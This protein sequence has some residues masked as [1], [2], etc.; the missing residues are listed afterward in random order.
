VKNAT[1]GESKLTH[2]A[3]GRVTSLTDF[4]GHTTTYDYTSG[5]PC[6][7]P[8]KIIN[9]DGTFRLYEY[10]SFGQTTLEVNELGHRTQWHYDDVGRLLSVTDAEGNTIRY[11]YE[12][13]LKTSETD[14]LGRTSRYAYND[15]NLQI[16]VTDAAGG[17]ARFEY[18]GNG[19]RTTVTDPVGNVTRFHYDGANRLT[20]EEDPYGHIRFY[21][22]DA[23][24]NRIEAIDRNGRRRT[25]EYDGLN[26]R[27]RELWWENG[28]VIRTFTYTFNALGV[29][30]GAG[31]PAGQLTF[32]Y[33]S[34][35]RLEQ[36]TQSGVPGLSDFTLNYAYDGMTNVVSVTD[37][38]GVQVTSDY[39]ARNRLSGRVWQGGGL[40]GASLRF[41]Y[42]PAGNRTRAERYADTAGTALV[43]QSA[44][45]YNPQG[46]MTDILHANGGGATLAEYHYQRDPAQQIVQ[47]VLNGQTADYGYDLTGQLTSAGFSAGQLNENY[48]YDANGN[49]IGGGYVVAPNNQIAADGTFTYGYDDEGSLVSRVSIA[50][51]ATTTY[52]FDHRNRLVSVVDT[53]SGGSVTQT[54]DFTY[55]ARDRRIAK[56]VNG[57]V[58]RFLLNQ[59]NIWADADGSGAITARYL[60]GNRID[61]MLARYRPG[62]A[63]VWYLGDH[64]STVRDLTDSTGVILNHIT[65]AAFGEVRSQLLAG[66][67]DRFL[68]TGRE[69]DPETG[70]IYMRA[71]YLSPA[72][73]RFISEDPLS[74]GQSDRNLYRYAA[75]S[76]LQYTDPSGM[77]AMIQFAIK[78]AALGTV[79]AALRAP[80]LNCGLGE[81]GDAVAKGLFVLAGGASGASLGAMIGGVY[82]YLGIGTNTLLPPTLISLPGYPIGPG[83]AAGIIGSLLA[84]LGYT[85]SGA[86]PLLDELVCDATAKALGRT[87][88]PLIV[89]DFGGS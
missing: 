5:C 28:A 80:G 38:W 83:R 41:D 26:R 15:A 42:D 23:A 27:T 53:D 12:G 4:N 29:M 71:R 79:V 60:L 56:S 77:I 1:G 10:N 39:D 25:F 20:R 9:P 55:D 7:K 74:F 18:D 69:L 70:L 37:N 21:T 22:Y 3:E 11:A 86:G 58:T 30:T 81:D 66:A 47:R 2:D 48:S 50:T 57:T 73:G 88:Q 19:N 40:L 44:Y 43:G 59:E 35:N 89:T 32:R 51:G 61:E 8:G 46:V 64:L 63:V 87:R 82:L 34:L 72:L 67:S 84:Y 75:N 24:G 36:A 49:R 85:H 65:Y 14:P 52:R 13:A 31:D 16:A 54:V 68:F 76:P 6:G 17:V 45:T 33:D 62:E 78:G